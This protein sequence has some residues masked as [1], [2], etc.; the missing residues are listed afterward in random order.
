MTMPT[1]QDI[2]HQFQA[3]FTQKYAVSP[4]Q[5]KATRDIMSCRTAPLGGHAS[6]CEACGHLVIR[7]HSCRN[8]H[9]PL[10]QGIKKDIWVDKRSKDI[11]HAPYFH[12]VFTIP[13]EL[14]PLLYQNQELLYNLLYKAVSQTLV[15]LSQDDAY[16]GA[17]IGFFSLLH[18]WSQDLHYHPHIHTV[19]LAGGLSKGNQWRKSRKKFFIPVKVLSK[20]FRG[21]FLDELKQYYHKNLLQF[22]GAAKSYQN[23]KAFQNLLNQCYSKNWYSYTKK[24]F[25]GPLAVMKYLGTYTHRIAISN[26]RIVAMSQDTVT[27]HVKDRKKNNQTKKITVS[28]V[29]FMRRFLLHVLPRGFVKIRHYGLLANRNKKTKLELSRKLT[30][31]PTYQA[32]FEGLKTTEIVSILIGKDITVCPTCGK[33]I[34]HLLYSLLPGASP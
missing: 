19:I 18:T 26:T 29:E 14:H 28:G 9:C 21:K 27:I 32:V 25:S 17:Q 1:V 11:L 7:Y 2:F 8:R 22:Y 20:K 15:E 12:N 3:P 31:S 6:R 23:P 13:K 4:Q 10:C 16:L 24:T 30:S 5:A 33:G 34:L